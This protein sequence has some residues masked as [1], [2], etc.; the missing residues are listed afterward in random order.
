MTLADVLALHEGCGLPVPVQ[1]FVTSEPHRF[2][3][4][5]E[6]IRNEL[7]AAEK[8]ASARE[9]VDEYED[10]GYEGEVEGEEGDA[11]VYEEGADGENEG[12]E[13]EGEYDEE[14]PEGECVGE[15]AEGEY[16]EEER[17]YTARVAQAEARADRRP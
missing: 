11:E 14:Q 3:T 4:R 12:D 6:A 7:D 10:E 16:A 17:E 9:S 15:E 13:A 8:R 1:L 5:F 2:I